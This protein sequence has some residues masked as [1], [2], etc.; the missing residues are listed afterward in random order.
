M[1]NQ[2]LKIKPDNGAYLDSLGWI[3][4]K[5]GMDEEALETLKKASDLLKDSVIHDHQGDV[6]FKLNRIE[7]AIAHWE[8]SL[9]L[10]PDQEEV[11]K[12]LNDVLN[13]QVRRNQ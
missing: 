11:I 12:K 4:H 2:A 5:K 6:Y 13:I 1:I 9:E 10:A 7:D 8:L 3:Y